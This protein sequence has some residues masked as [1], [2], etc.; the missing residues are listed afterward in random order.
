MINGIKKTYVYNDK[1]LLEHAFNDGIRF[2]VLSNERGNFVDIRRY[3]NETP[4][5]KGLRVTNDVFEEMIKMFD[6][7]KDELKLDEEKQTQNVV[8]TSQVIKQNPQLNSKRQKK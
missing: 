5:R 1:I 6:S 4:T 3:F 7:V 8:E 2:R